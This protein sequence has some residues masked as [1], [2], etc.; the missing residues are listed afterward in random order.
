LGL[1]GA[2]LGDR[3]QSAM[4]LRYSEPHHILETPSPEVPPKR[5]ISS[6]PDH[7]GIK[8]ED[9]MCPTLVPIDRSLED[10][11]VYLE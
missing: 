4:R 3:E 7:A 5:D 8:G 11:L 10:E 2:S 1:I 6:A 9:A